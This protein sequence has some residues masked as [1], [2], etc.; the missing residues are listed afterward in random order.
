[1][2]SKIAS[3]IEKKAIKDDPISV[4]FKLLD[5]TKGR[6]ML[7][8]LIIHRVHWT[9]MKYGEKQCLC[10]WNFS[11]QFSQL[12][13]IIFQSWCKSK[14]SITKY[15]RWAI[16]LILHCKNHCSSNFRMLGEIIIYTQAEVGLIQV[17]LPR[18]RCRHDA[19][20]T[21]FHF[22]QNEYLHAL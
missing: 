17:Y 11:R 8:I 22:K 9:W 19:M 18:K 16:N 7:W 15:H 12:Y 20:F 1:M 4:L 10:L 6:G 21:F 5:S 13:Q 14:K 3:D 2:N